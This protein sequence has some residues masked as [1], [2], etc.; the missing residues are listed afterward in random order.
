M[1]MTIAEKILARKSGRAQVK[2]GDVVR[3]SIDKAMVNDITAPLTVDA[4]KEIG[5]KE[6]WDPE[7]IV[8]VFDHQAPPTTIEAAEDHDS[9]RKFAREQ[10]IESIYGEFEG[11]CH[12]IMLEK[13][14]VLP[15]QLVVGADSHTCTYGAFG[16]FS[17]GIG[18]TDM[19]AVFSEGKLWFRVPESVKIKIKNK[20]KKRV[21]PKDLILKI[22]GDIGSD[23]AIYQSLEFTGSGVE[24]IDVPGRMTLCNMGVEM[25]A[26]SA[27]VPPDEKTEEYL[28]ERTDKDFMKIHPDPDAEYTDEREFSAS[29]LE[30]M[31][32][33]PHSVDNVSPVR[34][35]EGKEIQQA[36][37]GS[38]TNGR[39]EDLV[40]ATKILDGEKVSD[41]VRLLVAPASREVYLKALREGLIDKLIEAGATLEPPGCATCWG[42]HLGILAPGETCVTSS[43]RNFRGRMGSP[44]AEIYLASP[45]TVA[46]SSITGEITNPR[47]I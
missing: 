28:S 22:A 41:G 43:N 6:V 14:H 24:R 27:I 8:I 18:S 39:F 36:F 16:A 42:G 17:T 38:C 47:E 46:A 26:K 25:G 7:K 45:A 2:P 5:L 13:A 32:S 29:E 31:V 30:P 44:E 33:C 37:L 11:V 20:F 19:A 4:L 35:V 15:G 9:L 12:Q 40:T 3:A 21:G 23:G 10:G 1:G 34:E